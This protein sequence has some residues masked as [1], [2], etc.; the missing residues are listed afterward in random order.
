RPCWWRF[1][2]VPVSSHGPSWRAM[3]SGSMGS[4][5]ATV[6]SCAT[7]AAALDS[8]PARATSPKW[9]AGRRPA[10]RARATASSMQR[11][12]TAARVSGFAVFGGVG[13]EGAAFFEVAAGEGLEGVA[14]DEAGVWVFVVFEGGEG[15]EVVEQF[16]DDGGGRGFRVVLR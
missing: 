15:F 4:P 13:E 2:R 16:A 11:P 3:G 7:T 10:A 14:G 12:V 6:A 9:P 8:R 5:R 1:S